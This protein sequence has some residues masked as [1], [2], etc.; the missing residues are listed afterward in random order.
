MLDPT[1]RGHEAIA[2]YGFSIRSVTELEDCVHT[3]V[4][5]VL[6]TFDCPTVH[7]ILLLRTALRTNLS[8]NFCLDRK[9]LQFRLSFCY[10]GTE[11]PNPAEHEGKHSTKLTIYV[12]EDTSADPSAVTYKQTIARDAAQRRSNNSLWDPLDKPQHD[13]CSML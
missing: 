11:S 12:N 10:Q 8:G 13:D 5:S 7:S 1:H 4:N 3:N 2:L 6:F 9:Y